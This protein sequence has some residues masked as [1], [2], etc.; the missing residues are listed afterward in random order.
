MEVR[1]ELQKSAERW[2]LASLLIG[3]GIIPVSFGLAWILSFTSFDSSLLF[4]IVMLAASLAGFV[5]GVIGLLKSMR[6]Q[7]HTT[8]GI[9]LSSIGILLNVLILCGTLLIWMIADAVSQPLV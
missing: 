1:F 8:K 3:I 2:S 4:F 9:V 7:S 5:I 6:K